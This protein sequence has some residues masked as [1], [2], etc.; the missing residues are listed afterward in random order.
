MEA[1]LSGSLS[2]LLVG[3]ELEDARVCVHSLTET[4]SGSETSESDW[5]CQHP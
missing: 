1:F 2:F 4:I 5:D 3:L